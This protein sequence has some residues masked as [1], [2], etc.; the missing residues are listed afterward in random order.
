MLLLCTCLWQKSSKQPRVS[1]E[2]DDLERDGKDDDQ[3]SD[4]D[5]GDHDNNFIQKTA[6]TKVEALNH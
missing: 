3:K 5:G 6:E 4:S 1:S 2:E